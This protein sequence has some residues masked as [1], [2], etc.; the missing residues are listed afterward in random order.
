MEAGHYRQWVL[1]QHQAAVARGVT[2]APA[3]LIG[4]NMCAGDADL[5]QLRSAI[6]GAH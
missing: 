2:G 1:E 3:Y 6:R 5:E 4:G